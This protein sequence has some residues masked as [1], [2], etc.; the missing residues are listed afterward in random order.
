MRQKRKIQ[1]K[2]MTF[3]LILGVIINVLIGQNYLFCS[4]ATKIPIIYNKDYDFKFP[5]ELKEKH[6]FDGEKYSK[7]VNDLKGN[8]SA[9]S[10]NNFID[11][12]RE[13]ANEELSIVH[14]K[15][16]LEKYLKEP[17]TIGAIANVDQLKG[18]TIDFLEEVLLK[19]MRLATRGTV[20]A[21]EMAL[22]Y[23]WAINI[24]GGYH[25]AKKEMGE[26]FCFFADI[27]LACLNIL[28]KYGD[29]TK[30]LIVDLDA[31]EGNGNADFLGKNP[32]LKNQ[33]KIFDIYGRNN[34]PSQ[35]QVEHIEY[36][37]PIF[38][39]DEYDIDDNMYLETFL[40][41]ELLKVLSQFKPD[42]IIY[43][44][45]TD[46]F[47]KDP[48]GKMKVTKEGIIERDEFVFKSAKENNI[49][50]S[51]VLSGGY[52]KESYKIVS[53]SLL[54]LA[55][56]ELICLDPEKIEEYTQVIPKWKA[57]QK[58]EKSRFSTNQKIGITMVALLALIAGYCAYHKIKPFT[59][60]NK[61]Q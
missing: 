47:D 41:K 23:G 1:T 2:L 38:C 39:S 22:K 51:M 53:D 21:T 50:I 19:P 6:P 7:I 28:K 12:E 56:K 45:G 34:Y 36:N 43:N 13:I 24:G 61:S 3:Y 54:N 29:T 44:A 32:K 42:L 30:I 18:C 14:S 58:V 31:H 40:K 10:N 16:Y 33:I 59:V 60:W 49:A 11:P 52:H 55:Q 57:W 46:I 37:H 26:G 15:D 5:D 4:Q 9:L 27:P 20:I 35:N 17:K 48:L 25:H 8:S